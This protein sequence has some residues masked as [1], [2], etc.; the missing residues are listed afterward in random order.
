MIK[1][2]SEARSIRADYKR[3]LTKTTAKMKKLKEEIDNLTG[4]SMFERLMPGKRDIDAVRAELRM[5]REKES[6]LLRF[7]DGDIAKDKRIE[8]SKF[9]NTRVDTGG[10]TYQ[11]KVHEWVDHS[12]TPETLASHADLPFLA[13]EISSNISISKRA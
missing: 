2:D 12:D 5:L 6:M 4:R 1:A 9:V 7:L 10:R 8:V 3:K 13:L 11:F